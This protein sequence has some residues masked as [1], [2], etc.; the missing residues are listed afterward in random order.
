MQF[1][2]P[3][4]SSVRRIWSSLEL[5]LHLRKGSETRLCHGQATQCLH[6]LLPLT[7]TNADLRLGATPNRILYLSHSKFPF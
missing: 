1:C 4:T 5:L 6:S 3:L 2:I 7:P